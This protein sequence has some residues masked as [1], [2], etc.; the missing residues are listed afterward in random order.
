MATREDGVSFAKF[1][2]TA[3]PTFVESIQHAKVN[4]LLIENLSDWL[5]TSLDNEEFIVQEPTCTFKSMLYLFEDVMEEMTLP[6]YERYLPEA[7]ALRIY[8]NADL[9]YI[10]MLC[11]N[12]FHVN[13]YDMEKIKYIPP[14]QL[15]RIEKFTTKR[16]G[17]YR[18]M[19][20]HDI[21]D[22]FL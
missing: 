15:T 6:T 10:I 13:D 21:T 20:D 19:E 9:W 18:Q 22:Y 17:V 3:F 14:M 5:V 8:D 4:P 12:V 2:S 7:T 1:D 16:N 11:N